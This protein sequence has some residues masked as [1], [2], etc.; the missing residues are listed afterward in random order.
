MNM[1]QLDELLENGILTNRVI[2][3]FFSHYADIEFIPIEN[4]D[5][6]QA[7][8]C[9]GMLDSK[10]LNEYFNRILLSIQK[11]NLAVILKIF[12]QSNI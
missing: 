6:I 9:K 2:K 3:C 5:Y 11:K 4:N 1:T 7:F 10:Q 8:Y 12:H